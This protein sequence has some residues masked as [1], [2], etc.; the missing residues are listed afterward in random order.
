M[1]HNFKT[2]LCPTDFSEDSYKAI[3]YGR[4]FASMTGAKLLLAHIIHVPSGELYRPDGHIL[5]F[6]EARQRTVALLQELRDKRLGGYQPCELLV[7]IGDPFD[8]L[9][10]MSR[11]HNVDLIV[12]ATHGRSALADLVMGSVAE[13]IIR[14]APCPVFVVR[15][16][17]A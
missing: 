3:E 2:I 6:D 16:G 9:M 11:Q 5:T 4:Q 14:H 8:L 13:K 7:D 12:I 17:T 1:P 10:G 15:R